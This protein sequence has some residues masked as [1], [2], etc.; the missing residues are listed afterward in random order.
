MSV[1]VYVCLRLPSVRVDDEVAASVYK[2]R[3]N[4][5]DMDSITHLTSDN[6]HDA[7]A[8]SSLTVALFYLKCKAHLVCWPF[9][10]REH[11]KT[12]VLVVSPTGDAVSVTFLSSFIEVADRLT[13]KQASRSPRVRGVSNL[14]PQTEISLVA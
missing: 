9:N 8:Q 1:C 13:G 14:T 6:F 10:E 12:V 4:M 5:L 11:M 3:G 7:V 2:N